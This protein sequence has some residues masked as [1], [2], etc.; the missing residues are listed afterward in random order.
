MFC[1]MVNFNIY[2]LSKTL[3]STE[4]Y[5]IHKIANRQVSGA[6][7]NLY[8]NCNALRCRPMLSV[9]DISR[10]VADTLR[11]NRHVQHVTPFDGAQCNNREIFNSPCG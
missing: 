1:Y 2:E 4:K 6:S 11:L 8:V 7:A 9:P 5:I 10:A 3:Q